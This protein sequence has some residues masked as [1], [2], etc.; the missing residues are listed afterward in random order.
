LQNA[1]VKPDSTCQIESVSAKVSLQLDA[2]INNNCVTEKCSQLKGDDKAKAAGITQAKTVLFSATNSDAVAEDKLSE[3]DTD[4]DNIDDD[5]IED[6]TAASETISNISN[7]ENKIVPNKNVKPTIEEKTQ[8]P[9]SY[10]SFSKNSNNAQ[11]INFDGKFSDEFT[12]SAWIR[13]PPKVNRNVKEQIFC[14]TDSKSMNRH[15]YGLYFYHGNLKFLLRR[16][17]SDKQDE[18]SKSK[19]GE[20]AGS[21]SQSKAAALPTDDPNSNEQ[22]ETFYPSLWEWTLSDEILN[23]AKWH[24]YEVRFNYPNVS[25]YIDGVHFIENTSNSDIID[26]Y[27]LNNVVETESIVTYVGACYHGNL[28]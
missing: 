12:L 17:S 11:L 14:G 26:A 19:N 23:D 3:Q 28:A 13:Q 4:S 6:D 21:A 27:E 24:N 9:S 16:E 2:L 25:L 22:G 20:V 10:R 18:K 15:H 1:D 7:D 5:S 8:T